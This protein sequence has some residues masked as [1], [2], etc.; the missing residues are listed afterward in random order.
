MCGRA[1]NAKE[2]NGTN[3][4]EE[5]RWLQDAQVSGDSTKAEL[6]ADGLT[7]IVSSWRCDWEAA[8]FENEKPPVQFDHGANVALVSTIVNMPNSEGVSIYHCSNETGIKFFVEC[9]TSNSIHVSG[10]WVHYR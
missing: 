7:F 9:V 6:D 1:G 4:A 8:V 10:I 3:F 2:Y 5:T